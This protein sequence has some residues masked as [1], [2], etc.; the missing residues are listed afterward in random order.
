MALSDPL[1]GNLWS[2][3][4]CKFTEKYKI[5]R[6]DQSNS[7]LS[8]VASQK[9]LWTKRMWSTCQAL[10]LN[11]YRACDT[12]TFCLPPIVC[13]LHDMLGGFP[14]AF[15]WFL[16]EMGKCSKWADPAGFLFCSQFKCCHYYWCPD[17]WK[18]SSSLC[19]ILL[20]LL[21]PSDN[22]DI[23][24][25]PV[26]RSGTGDEMASLQNNPFTRSTC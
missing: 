11:L 2:K 10:N 23:S 4:S 3:G 6:V 16:L 8:P 22:S 15:H 7:L 19:F 12:Q 5:I 17:G 14:K 20:T 25:Q 24:L 9:A 1:T 13:C 26:P 18:V 21:L